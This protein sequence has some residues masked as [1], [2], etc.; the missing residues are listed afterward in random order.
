MPITWKREIF[1]AYVYKVKINL[2]YSGHSLQLKILPGGLPVEE[3]NL[4]CKQMLQQ[5]NFYK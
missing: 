5:H 4:N 2:F 3:C 1:V